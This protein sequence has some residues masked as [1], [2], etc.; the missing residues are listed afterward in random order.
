MIDSAIRDYK[1]EVNSLFLEL[2]S[3][4]D[5]DQI[6]AYSTKINE[7][8]KS[9]ERSQPSLMF[10][11]I[12]N[13]GKSSLLNAIFGEE[14]ASVN[15]IPETHKV[16]N[17]KWKTFTLVDTPGLN[18]PEDDEKIT[19]Q[20]VN[21]HD[22]I[23]FVIDD[24]DNFDSDVI[25]KKIVEII[26][27]KKPCIIVINKK[28]DS[29]ID[30][31][32]GIQGK[33]HNNIQQF[34]NIP[35][36]YDFI[37]VNA[38]SALKAKKEN[39]VVLLED[40]NI[41]QLEHLISKK[42]SSVSQVSMLRIP[43]D[44]II[45]LCTLI[46]QGIDKAFETTETKKILELQQNIDDVKE[47]IKQLFSVELKQKIDAY[48]DM[49]YNKLASSQKIDIDKTQ[50]E[51]EIQLL[52]KKYEKKYAD[53]CKYEIDEFSENWKIEIESNGIPQQNVGDIVHKKSDESTKDEIDELLDILEKIPILIPSPVPTP[54]P[55]PLPVIVA[56]VKLLKKWLFGPKEE[57]ID[58]D[59]LNERQRQHAR[60]REMA[61]KQLKNQISMQ[62]DNYYV[63]IKNTFD[64]EIDKAYIGVSSKMKEL[65]NEKE[66]TKDLLIQKKETAENIITV[67]NSIKQSI[68]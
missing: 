10:Y 68:V 3:L 40:S 42:L 31:I 21:K 33:M 19:M 34:S 55:I 38:V 65:I 47:N 58:I 7:I 61:L 25:T 49:M 62:M 66:S 43:L 46:S 2:K 57:E 28:N 20:E 53:E 5:N 6:A 63:T 44:M 26:E 35:Q 50:C 18:G 1:G 24:S 15:D 67:A 23:M 54:V 60:E 39:K 37:S 22:I 30:R 51:Q 12:Y 17:Y 41:Q 27:A 16:T 32:L 56:A 29:D 59:E 9:L 52:I 48:A 45:E 14:M 36:N 8:E 4:L 64:S 11:G 13:A